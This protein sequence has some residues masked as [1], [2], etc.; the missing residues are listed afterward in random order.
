MSI[1]AR[2]HA[3]L[4]EWFPVAMALLGLWV[5]SNGMRYWEE[6]LGPSWARAAARRKEGV[7]SRLYVRVGGEWRLV[8]VPEG[9]FGR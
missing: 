2:T 9:R 3:R 7:C 1:S 6:R 5:A 4:A 8:I